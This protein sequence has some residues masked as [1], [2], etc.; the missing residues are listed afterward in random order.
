MRGV[1]TPLKP[2]LL[3]QA[4]AAG[5]FP[6][7]ES[8]DD[9]E[10]FWVD[11]RHRGILPL[12]GSELLAFGLRGHV[13]HSGDAGQT[14]SEPIPTGTTALLNSAI[15]PSSDLVIVAGLNGVMLVSRD[16]GRS[17]GFTQQDDRKSLAAV[18]WAGDGEVIVAGETGLRRLAVPGLR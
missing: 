7:A 4:Y 10:V 2:E 12:D 9:P 6:M 1:N 14:W 13:F 8:R 11:P 17:F 15:R 18:M 16:G 5:V 3:L